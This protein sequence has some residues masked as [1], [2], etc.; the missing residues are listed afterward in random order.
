MRRSLL[1]AVSVWQTLGLIMLSEGW[2]VLGVVKFD[3]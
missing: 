3:V 2:S 1:D